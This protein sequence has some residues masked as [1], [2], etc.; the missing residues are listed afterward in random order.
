MYMAV[1][2]HQPEDLR[3][4]LSLQLFCLIMQQS[5]MGSLVALQ[6]CSTFG[7]QE[8]LAESN[9]A[10]VVRSALYEHSRHLGTSPCLQQ[11]AIALLL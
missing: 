4:Q 1:E 9:Q 3:Q 6:A 11:A 2:S 8:V 10:W 7:V 5:P